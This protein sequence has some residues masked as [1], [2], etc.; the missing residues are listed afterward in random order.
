MLGLLKKDSTSA[1]VSLEGF[2]PAVVGLQR[3]LRR[4]AA[5]AL[6]RGGYGEG[7]LIVVSR[8]LSGG[9]SP[10]RVWVARQEG[11]RV[12]LVCARWRSPE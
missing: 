7:G 10:S 6:R 4:R 3:G 1:F 2:A 12:A 8:A 5:V 9:E 11:L